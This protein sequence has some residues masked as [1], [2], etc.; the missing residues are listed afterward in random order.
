M[1]SGSREPSMI[2]LVTDRRRLT[3]EPSADQGRACLVEQVRF[4]V[5]AGVD[6]VQVR[7]RDLDAKELAALVSSL[8]AVTRG[9]H[10]SLVVNDRLDVA[11]ACGADGVHLRGDSIAVDDARSLT[12]DSFLIGRS[13]HSV[14]DAIRAAR[15]DYLIVGS[16]FP[17]VSKPQSTTWLGIAGLLAI[18]R[19]SRPPVLA[20]GGIDDTRFD[21]I[22][23]TGAAGIAAIG[24]F[25]RNGESSESESGGACRTMR[26]QDLVGSARAR[27]DSAVSRP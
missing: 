14:E 9:S 2:C 27:F 22:A 17:S 8:L 23:A 18:V 4:A 7:E 3:V 20:I 10:T 16:V 25:V 12:P 11:L 24:L 19:A 26:L 21:E 5:E 13:V 1:A 15:A 6:L